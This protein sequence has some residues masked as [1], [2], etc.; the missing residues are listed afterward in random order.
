MQTAFYKK[1]NICHMAIH[2]LLKANHTPQSFVWN[3]KS[4]II[5]TGQILT[6]RK[7]LANETGQSQQQV[8]TALLTL[9][10]PTIGFL[11]IKTTNK[12]SLI[13]IGKYGEYQE[14]STTK[15]TNKQPTTNQQL[16]TNKNDKNVKNDKDLLS[17]PDKPD[18]ELGKK[19]VNWQ[20]CSSAMQRVVATY[21][22]VST[23]ALY[24]PGGCTQDQA[25]AIFKVQ[26]KAVAPILAQCGGDAD[27]A[28]RVVELAAAHYAK[29][30][31][32]WSLYAV[33]KSCSDWLNQIVKEKNYGSKR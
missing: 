22:R 23:P 1:P 21:V 27:M 29:E 6:G 4:E 19:P 2:L 5:N 9:S 31:L 10:D 33:A 16:T 3:G 30:G 24:A 17:A 20:N 18:A 15:L 14:L 12:F 8:R 7:A 26:G 11:T 25:T 28:C 32:N 13:S